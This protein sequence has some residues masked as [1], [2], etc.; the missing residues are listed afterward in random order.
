VSNS[1]T[2]EPG[3][4]RELLDSGRSA[5]LL[6]VRTPAEFQTVH[7]PGSYNVP[8]DL[9]REHRD[10]I[11]KHLEHDVVLV[12]RSGQRAA[13]AQETLRS[14]GLGNVHILDGGIT[15][16][17][18][19]GFDVN[20]GAQRWDLERQVRLVAGSIVF[21]SILGSIAV[22]KL[23]LLAAGMGGGLALAAWSNSCVMGMLLS[24][25]PYNRGRTCDPQTIIA[26]LVDTPV[27]TAK[28]S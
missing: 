4:L 21:T 5:R 27:E 15:A 6:D 9:L 13:H 24:R 26:Q 3:Q 16:W 7:I 10:E 8:L 12:C 22:P 19:K 14:A 11:V 18:G 28:A 20:R 2:I 25:L 17:Q 23:K 1:S